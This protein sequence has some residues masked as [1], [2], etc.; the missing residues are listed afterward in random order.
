M[1]SNLWLNGNGPQPASPGQEVTAAHLRPIV[2]A[3][4]GTHATSADLT[5]HCS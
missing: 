3:V 5:V 1:D 4:L 2:L